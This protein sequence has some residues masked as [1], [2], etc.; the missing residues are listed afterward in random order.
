MIKELINNIKDRKNKFIKRIVFE[1][2]IK[3]TIKNFFPNLNQEDIECIETLTIF[4]IDFISFK[5]GFGQDD[6]YYLQW[7]QNNCS[8]IKGVILLLLPFID[9]KNNSYLL[10]KITDLN[11][12]LYSK[13]ERYIP[14]KIL[15]LERDGI[16]GALQ[17]NFKYGNMG[18][19]LL[20]FM[21]EENTDVLL[22]LYPNNEKLIYKVIENNFY[23][24]IQTIEIINGKNYIN[25][26]NIQPL[27]LNNYNE[28][29]IYKNTLEYL[30][31]DFYD[32]LI[33]IDLDYSGLWL[34]D[35][36]NVIRNKFYEDCKHLKWFFFP[37]DLQSGSKYLIQILNPFVKLENIINHQFNNFDDL[38]E[39]EQLEFKKNLINVIDN[40]LD[41]R[42]NISVITS[43]IFW[44]INNYSNKKI[45][46]LENDYIKKFI[47]KKEDEMSN[48]KKE[49][50]KDN[51]K[52]D[53]VIE[54][55]KFI[56]DNLINHFW[57]FLNQSTKQL[58][59]SCYGKYLFER[60]FKNRY[61]I[62][63]N[64]IY[65]PL[66]KNNKNKITTLNIKNI[67]NISKS[68]SNTSFDVKEWIPWDKNYISINNN[69]RILFFRRI[70][71][72]DNSWFNIKQ[73]Y[74]KEIMFNPVKSNKTET[75]IN[76]D[77]LQY[78]R[79]ILNEFKASLLDLIFEELV[80]SGIL[81]KFTPNINIT[82][83]TKLPLNTT[84]LQKKRKD[85]IKKMFK[86]NKKDWEES[87][88]Y[89][90]NEKFKYM[91]KLKNPRK[92][93]INP[94]DK[95][96]E[97]DYFDMISEEQEWTNFY[98][99][100]WISQ[101]SFF[102]HYI[103]HQVLYVTGATG[104]GKST[105]VPKLLLYALKMYDYN[106]KGNVIC[107]QPRINPT[108][109]NATRIAE[110]LGLPIE[111][112]SNNS[113]NKIKTDNY[114]VQYKYER[115]EHTKIKSNHLS[116][117]IVTDG[118]LLE[119]IKS[120]PILKKNNDENMNV[121][122]SKELS[123]K[124]SNNN[125]FDIIIVDEAHE[126]NI[127]MD[128]IIA[129]AKQSC[130][131]NNQVKL[132]IV[133]AT[134]DDDEPIYRSYFKCIND[135]LVYPIKSM[136]KNPFLEEAILL[137]P[138]YMD[139][140]YHISPPGETTQYKVNEI[141]LE[142]DIKG[143]T[144]KEISKKAQELGYEKIIE[145]CNKTSNGEILFFCN[146]KNEILEAVE[147]LN[148]NMPQGNIA[149]PFFAEMNDNYKEI[150]TKI[151]SKIYNIKNRRE[152]I[153]LEWNEKYIEDLSIP[154]GL[155]KRAVIIA[156]NVAEA[157]VTIPGLTF[158]IDNGYAKGNTFNSK[159]GINKLIVDLISE[160][161]RL[162]RKGRVGR[163]S[164]GTVYYLYKKDAR[165]NIKPKYKITQQDIT[166]TF[167]SLANNL[168]LKE[169]QSDPEN[170]KYKK[171][172]VSDVI[173]PNK[174]SKIDK[175]NFDENIIKDFFTN[176]Y[177]IEIYLN[178]YKINNFFL[179]Y[180][181]Y[182]F[183]NKKDFVMN[184]SLSVYENGQTFDNL[185]DK[186]GDF[187]L[188]HSFENS[189]K[190]N[191]LNNIIKY[192]NKHIDSIPLSEFKNFFRSLID[193]N[194]I[195][196][197][198]GD[199]LYLYN[200]DII[201][202]NRRFEK[203]ELA[204]QIMQIKK[205]FDIDKIN[206]A[207]TL[208][209]SSAM[210]CLNQILEIR[211]FLELITNLPS[212]LMIEDKKW[213]NFKKIF[214]SYE[215]NS[216]ILFIY[217]IIKEIKSR[218]SH[219]LVFNINDSINKKLD[220]YIDDQ[221]KN[222]KKLVRKSKEPPLNYDGK[223]WNKLR[224]LE[225]NGSLNL[226][227]KELFLNEAST[228]DFVFN[229]IENYKKEIES[230]ASTLY[231]K[232]D[233]I[234]SFIKKLGWLYLNKIEK[235][236]NNKVVNWSKK[237]T[238]NFNKVLTDHTLEEKIIRSFVYGNP[239]QFTFNESNKL[240]TLI[241]FNLYDIELAIPFYSKRKMSD[242]L[243]NVDDFIFFLNFEQVESSDNEYDK[244]KISILNKIKPIWLL[245]ALP[246]VH[247][248]MFNNIYYDIKNNSI[249]MLDSY[250]IDKLNKEFKNGWSTNNFVWNISDEDTAPIMHIFYKSII[251]VL[252]NFIH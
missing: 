243:A 89:L 170:Y 109:E 166:D 45:M 35:F 169:Y 237:F 219:L 236:N 77:Y 134:M 128:I 5:Y 61:I 84:S 71:T 194:L 150:I 211:I 70:S 50:N 40:N 182:E 244:I 21:K 93:I 247:N 29:T 132:I 222:Y 164:D 51:I 220:T 123:S 133:S 207:I 86:D 99:M 39:F 137:D 3:E 101:I 90:T 185:I 125:Y 23:G 224:N 88:Y 157:S 122:G 226:G 201:N 91:N 173:N 227:K 92:Q 47:L 135:K 65:K 152:N 120:N 55:F 26:I 154:A 66:N 25:W 102:Q 127:N 202:V 117:K 153:H 129:L 10:K 156:T 1:D 212:N 2:K 79:K 85:Y 54:A 141:Y 165:K 192:E 181:Y 8:D 248:P 167:I 32:K 229:D 19:G 208:I 200:N 246:L 159:L 193:K 250:T 64:F 18:L 242:S 178:N 57:N 13:S 140:R 75:D 59:V 203:T 103:F 11:H 184:E 147:Y 158:V 56:K 210:G 60:D 206:D 116:L 22:D 111:E 43:T 228:T 204:I 105:Q 148:F 27:N 142:N 217:R 14:N 131:F 163:V 68:L 216:D 83:K 175:T 176:K 104:Q 106:Y 98:A 58:I 183:L 199:A 188:I 15:E 36:Y 174:F 114:Y 67:Y 187:Y 37:Y 82:D 197:F 225:I 145:I 115:G 126:H 12:I 80:S 251:G 76:N 189:I 94:N 41:T 149:L 16:D 235:L 238:N 87:Y 48:D 30:K 124:Y 110:E 74:I 249:K 172:I 191:V 240:K 49:Y 138:V 108:L 69:N 44:F 130:Y 221:V 63:D 160:S 28:S 146:G 52:S 7:Q 24:L 168:D 113:V 31:T 245:H 38:D 81:N 171:L 252:K 96:Q 209:A 186:K 97:K 205:D 118:T 177:L 136:I 20:P 213:D 233:I 42:L 239:I 46:D 234:I 232:P 17:T 119:I 223:K 34:G 241:N 112:I 195:I 139:R 180:I 53:D 144:H 4:T 9:D 161:S 179:P 230:W 121:E 62:S 107:T 198:K 231:F 6:I 151:N 214:T 72:Q 73:N 218:F 95:Y 33:T 143:D 215:T 196:D 162:Q 100:N 190:R 155:Y 78:K